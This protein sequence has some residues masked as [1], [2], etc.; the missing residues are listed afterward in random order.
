MKS[1]LF[2]QLLLFCVLSLISR[3]LGTSELGCRDEN[4]VIVDWYYLYKLPKDAEHKGKK[5]KSDGLNYVYI[6]SNT[7]FQNGSSW[8]ESQMKIDD[9]NSIPGRTIVQLYE[10]ARCVTFEFLSI[11]IDFFY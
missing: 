6:T 8:D 9:A 5:T 4:N 2:L 3:V 11:F 1:Q 7:I 10:N